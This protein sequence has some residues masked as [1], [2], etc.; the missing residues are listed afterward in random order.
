M[1]CAQ[2]R[3]WRRQESS[4]REYVRLR[5]DDSVGI[6][7]LG[8]V[9]NQRDKHEESIVHLKMSM[10]LGAGAYDLFAYYADSHEKLGHTGDAHRMVIQT[11]NDW[12]RTRYAA[13][14]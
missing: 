8:F 5:P 3:D 2:L 4:W 14:K 7:R 6:A 12:G 1:K 13:P 11:G 10:D 9:L